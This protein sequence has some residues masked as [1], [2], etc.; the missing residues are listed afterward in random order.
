M[1]N[2]QF[3][4][5]LL[6]VLILAISLAVFALAMLGRNRY[7]LVKHILYATFVLVWSI[8]FIYLVLRVGGMIAYWAS[9]LF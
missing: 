7:R 1:K 6:T 5:W 8:V 4:F 9:S 3:L 2:W